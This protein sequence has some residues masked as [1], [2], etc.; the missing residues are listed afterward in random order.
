M[1]QTIHNSAL[2][3]KFPALNVRGTQGPMNFPKA[4]TESQRCSIAIPVT[5]H[6]LAQRS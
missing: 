6:R 2:G 4:L 1:D 5:S 3:D